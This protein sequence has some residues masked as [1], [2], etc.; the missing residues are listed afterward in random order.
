MNK[1]NRQIEKEWVIAHF[2]SSNT[3]TI[4]EGVVGYYKLYSEF[5]FYYKENGKQNAYYGTVVFIG[6]RRIHFIKILYD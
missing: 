1:S 6:K 3:Y 4:A 2:K 5:K